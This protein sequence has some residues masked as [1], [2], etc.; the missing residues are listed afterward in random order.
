MA[1]HIFAVGQRVQLAF[2]RSYGDAPPGIYTVVRLLPNGS[3]GHEYRVKSTRDGHERVV[4]EVQ[5]RREPVTQ[6][7]QDRAFLARMTRTLKP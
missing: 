3:N 6:E 4:R 2:G 5:I 7:R 1:L